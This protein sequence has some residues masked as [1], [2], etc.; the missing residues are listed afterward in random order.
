MVRDLAWASDNN[1][2]AADNHARLFEITPTGPDSLVATIGVGSRSL[3]RLY[4]DPTFNSDEG[5][6]GAF[7]QIC[8]HVFS[9]DV[10]IRC[11][12]ATDQPV[13]VGSLRGIAASGGGTDDPES[14]GTSTP[15]DPNAVPAP[16]DQVS[17]ADLIAELNRRAQSGGL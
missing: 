12:Q 17:T 7:G 11:D 16:L 6:D 9:T 10:R 1:G 4:I 2:G 13:P 8:V 5:G 15:V 3:Y 14:P